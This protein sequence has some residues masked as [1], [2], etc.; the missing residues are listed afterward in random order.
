MRL[1][2]VEGGVLVISALGSE[3]VLCFLSDT[4]RCSL[5]AP[6]WGAGRPGAPVTALM[7]L[8]WSLQDDFPFLRSLN[9]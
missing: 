9:L 5:P 2:E 1:Q 3:A 6:R 4:R 8:C 7:C